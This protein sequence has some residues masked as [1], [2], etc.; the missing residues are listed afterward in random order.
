MLGLASVH[1]EKVAMD[2]MTK[3]STLGTLGVFKFHF[4]SCNNISKHFPI[5]FTKLQILFGGLFFKGFFM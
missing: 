5:L 4:V 1:L 2:I 3:S